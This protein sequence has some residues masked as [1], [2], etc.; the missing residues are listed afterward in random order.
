MS[1]KHE[2]Q[3]VQTGSGREVHMP[4]RR[5]CHG[6]A[7]GFASAFFMAATVL[8]FI[9]LWRQHVPDTLYY[10][11]VPFFVVFGVAGFGLVAI[12][13][14]NPVWFYELLEGSG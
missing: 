9:I 11:S 5:G 4:Y 8:G 13:Y 2:A 14:T 3:V 12:A 7:I 6:Y 10:T 1:D